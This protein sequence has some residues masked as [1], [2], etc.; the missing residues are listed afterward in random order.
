MIGFITFIHVIVC[1][2]LIAVVLMQSGRGGGL[3]EAFS[4]AENFFGAKTNEV[5]IKGTAI[6]AS[7]F[8]VTCL[9]LAYFSAKRDQ[10]L[11]ANIAAK[12]K[13]SESLDKT[14]ATSEASESA[15]AL[16]EG[17]LPAEVKEPETLPEQ[18]N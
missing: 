11:M 14:K 12:Q 15:D 9:S 13:Q 4:S 1:I 18:K 2:L 6:L 16:T 5:L 8:I 3:T 10:S 7:I 17:A